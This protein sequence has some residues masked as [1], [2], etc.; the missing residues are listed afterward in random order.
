MLPGSNE[1]GETRVLL[2]MDSPLLTQGSSSAA[3]HSM[4]CTTCCRALCHQEHPPV[5]LRGARV[6]VETVSHDIEFAY[7]LFAVIKIMVQV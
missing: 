7:S 2:S 5:R 1:A 4:G 6:L 3:A